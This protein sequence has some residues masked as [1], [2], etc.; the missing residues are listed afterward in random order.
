MQT[1]AALVKAAPA[2][3]QFSACVFQLLRQRSHSSKSASYN[4]GSTIKNKLF[5]FYT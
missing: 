2:E 1:G 5:K 4:L 3:V